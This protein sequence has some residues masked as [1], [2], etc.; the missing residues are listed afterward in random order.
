MTDRRYDE[1]NQ[2][3]ARQTQQ[4]FDFYF[5]AL[6]F[7]ILGLSIQTSVM[8]LLNWQRFFEILSWVCLLL[9]GLSGLSRLEWISVAFRQ[10]GS[11]Q[12][13]M[14]DAE[15]TE[16]GLAGAPILKQ[17]GSPMSKEEII[18]MKKYYKENIDSRTEEIRRIEKGMSFKYKIHKWGFVIGLCALII[19]RAM[20]KLM[21]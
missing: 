9:S 20:Q 15:K 19:S 16:Q 14:R 8:T 2:E 21:V 7:T 3:Y 10:Y 5:I 17:D 12:S 13:D 1:A 6:V 18:K 4:K 11:R